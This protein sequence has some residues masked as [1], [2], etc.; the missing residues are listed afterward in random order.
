MTSTIQEF[1]STH[2]HEVWLSGSTN[3]CRRN[4]FNPHTYMRC[5]K[6]PC[7][8]HFG[9]IKF[10]STHL[11]EVWQIV[12][13]SVVIMQVFQSTHLHEVWLGRCCTFLRLVRFNPHTY[14]RCDMTSVI[15]DNFFY[16]SIHTPTWGVTMSSYYINF[17]IYVSIH[18]PTWGVT[19]YSTYIDPSKWFQST[20]LHEV[21]LDRVANIFRYWGFQSTHL[22]EVWLRII[23]WDLILL[24]V[25]IHTPTWGVTYVG[26]CVTDH[27]LF[28]STHLHEVWLP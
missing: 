14:M 26:F 16:V 5:D 28:Q 18:T 11:H 8:C 22:H 3:R 15:M 9:V 6:S 7:V 4:S 25:S 19:D 10:Q 20:H 23:D 1:Q 2:L 21:W 27:F 13:T 12:T 17:Q 24:L